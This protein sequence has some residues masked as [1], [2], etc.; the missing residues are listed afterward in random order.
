MPFETQ[1][2]AKPS[3]CLKTSYLKYAVILPKK[4]HFLYI[5]L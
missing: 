2:I 5:L 4:A 1:R 3:D